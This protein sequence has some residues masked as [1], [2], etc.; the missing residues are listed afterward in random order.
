MDRVTIE[1]LIEIKRNGGKDVENKQITERINLLVVEDN[2]ELSGI[3]ENFFSFM[4]EFQLC[5]IAHDG[6]D[7][8]EQIKAKQPDVVLL[9][10]I[11]PKLDGISVLKELQDYD[12]QQKPRIVVTSAIQQDKVTKEAIS[13]GANYY[14]SKPYDLIKLSSLLKEVCYWEK[15]RA[16]GV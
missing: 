16:C 2:N 13:L 4:N 8:L 11:M 10:L 1:K 3:L 9:D 5:G 6:E 15:D 14:V 7:A 12:L